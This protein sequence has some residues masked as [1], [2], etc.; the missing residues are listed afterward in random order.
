M[1]GLYTQHTGDK[2]DQIKYERLRLGLGLVVMVRVRVRVKI[3]TG[4]PI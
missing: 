2:W 4:L 3:R 1:A